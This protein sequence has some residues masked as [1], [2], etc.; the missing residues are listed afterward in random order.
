[1]SEREARL[2]LTRP[3]LG[4]VYEV[5]ADTF[6]ALALQ[7]RRADLALCRVELGECRDKATL[8]RRLAFALRLP[9]DFGDNWDALADCLRDPS[10]Q[11]AWGH[12]LLFEH[13]QTLR[14]TDPDSFAVLLGVL[15]DAATFAIEHD[16][17]FFAFFAL[18]DGAPNSGA[19]LP[20]H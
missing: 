19:A 18:P 11:P 13:S 5:A 2:D 16:R 8:L 7:A 9:A 15:D 1:M 12:V 3:L 4:G 20:S 10:W 17:P 6:D 14:D